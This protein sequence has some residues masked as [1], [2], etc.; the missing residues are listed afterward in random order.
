MPAHGLSRTGVFP[1]QDIDVINTGL[2]VFG[3]KLDTA[4]QQEFGVVI[5]THSDTNIGQ[6]THGL[7]VV[8]VFLQEIP[9]QPFG[10]IQFFLMD[11]IHDVDQFRWQPVEKIQPFTGTVGPFS[12]CRRVHPG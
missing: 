12:A 6:E 7:N 1:D 11:E 4:F 5:D 2:Y 10:L 8:L 3:R 9:A